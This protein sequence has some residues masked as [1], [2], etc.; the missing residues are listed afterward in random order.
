MIRA[1]PFI[2]LFAGCSPTSALLTIDDT[3]DTGEPADV[4]DTDTDVEDDTS[5]Y[6]GSTLRILEPASGDFLPLGEW[7]VFRA[8]LYDASGAEMDYDDIQWSSSVD[9]TWKP[10]GRLVED[11]ALG[12]GIH[13]LTAQVELPNGDRLAHTVGGVLVQSAF[14]GTYV[15]LFTSDV[16]YDAYTTACSGSATLIVDPFGE[17]VS[18]DATCIASLMGYDAELTYL[19]DLDNTHGTVTGTVSADI[20]GWFEYDFDASGTLFPQTSGLQI[21]FGGDVYSMLAVDGALEAERISMD[22]GL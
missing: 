3:L 17:I 13:D 22:A 12:V 16:T 1:L 10:L 20:F 15:G 4:T 11:G 18:G 8:A 6:D 7:Q 2:V 19:F 9:P 14:A 21:T 5:I